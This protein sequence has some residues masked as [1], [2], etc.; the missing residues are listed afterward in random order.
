MRLLMPFKSTSEFILQWIH[1]ISRVLPY[2]NLTEI[3]T[4]VETILTG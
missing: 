2:T 3:V 4:A 1:E